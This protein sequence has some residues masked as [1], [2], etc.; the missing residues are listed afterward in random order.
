MRP[1][2]SIFALLLSGCVTMPET[3]APPVQ[4]KPVM[5]EEFPALQSRIDMNHPAAPMHLVRDVSPMLESGAWRWAYEKPTVMLSAPAEKGVRFI[6]DIT[7][8]EVTFRQTGPVSIRVSVNGRE[9][10][11]VRYAAAGDHQINLKVPDGL[12]MKGADTTIIMQ[13]DKV[14][15]RHAFILTRIGLVTQ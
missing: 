14:H 1:L 8:P 15:E 9:I 10:G 11:S 13:Q 2:A 5:I 3:Y 7:L 6:A 12:L 4:R